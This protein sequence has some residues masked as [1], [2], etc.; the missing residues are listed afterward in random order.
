MLT[1]MLFIGLLAIAA[2]AVLPDLIFEIKRDREEEM[3]HRGVQYTR[4]VRRYYRKFGSY[5]VTLDQLDATNNIKF[6]RKRYKDPI[7]GQDFKLFLSSPF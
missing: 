2:T 4:A 3:V 7:T 6:L 5:P 1:L